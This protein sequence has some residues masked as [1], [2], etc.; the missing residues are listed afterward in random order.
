MT[1]TRPHVPEAVRSRWPSPSQP[2][3]LLA[4]VGLLYAVAQLVLISPRMGI[5]WDEAVYAGQYAAHA[6]PAPFSAPRAR[7]VPLLVAPVVAM[8]DSVL[9]LRLYLTVVSSLALFGAF[10]VWARVRADRSV[11]LA[12]LLFAGCWL[13]LFYGNEAMPNL[14]VALGGV[15]ATGFL[16][17]AVR[18][19][20]R[21]A[22]ETGRGWDPGARQAWGAPGG[23][24]RRLWGPAAGLGAALAVVSLMR[25]SDALV[26]AVPLAVAALV[27]LRRRALVPLAAVAAGLAVGW[28]QWLVEAELAYGGVAAR[29][30]GAGQANLTGWTVSLLEHARALDGPSLCR[31]G[32]RCGDVSPVALVW[33]LAIP[34]MTLLGLWT[35]RRAGGLGPLLLAT[36]AGTVSALPYFFYVGYAA[37]RFLMPAYA[38][39]SL[40]VARAVTGLRPA[41]RWRAPAGALLAVGVLAHLALQGTYAYRMA[42]GT[43]RDRERMELAAHA[44]REAGVRP[45]CLVHGQSG[46]QIGYLIGCESQGVTRRFSRRQPDRVRAAI[47]RGAQ[48]VIVHTRA[49][50]PPYARAWRPLD[51]PGPWKARFAP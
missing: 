29:M 45:P 6:P 21:S 50:L 23:A 8:T 12:A 20:R 42:A 31:F 37:P 17:L 10:L 48:V 22:T 4:L 24:A 32:V 7:G 14:Y 1:V 25:P 11:P 9:V 27:L 35:A 51:L 3:A 39:L 38:L 18:A 26:L 2:V 13:S 36:A 19:V 43:Y 46:V 16:V 33:W 47:D 41:G 49:P 5:G 44:L 34:L 15:A 40:P 28:G 30:R